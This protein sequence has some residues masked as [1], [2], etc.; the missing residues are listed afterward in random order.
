MKTKNNLSL[1]KYNT[2]HVDAKA[3]KLVIID[4]EK[5]ITNNLSS[6]TSSKEILILGGGS[7]I[8]FTKD[9][10]GTILKSN[11]Q[12][13]KAIEKDKEHIYLKVG[14]G[15][16]WDDLVKYAVKKGYGGIENL[17][18]IPGTVGAAPIQNIGAYGV[19]FDEVFFKLEGINLIDGSKKEYHH[20]DCGFGYRTSIFKE[21][22]KNKFFITYVTIRLDLKP[23]LKTNYR[24]IKE[25]VETQTIRDLDIKKISEIIREIRISK[26]PDPNKLGNAGSFFKNPVID[27]KHFNLLAAKYKDLVYFELQEGTYKIPAGWLIE[28]VGLKGKRFGNVAVHENQALVIVNLGNAT[29]KEVFELAQDIKKYIHNKF[30]INLEMEVNII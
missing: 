18:L 29:G 20:N 5:D 7:N 17:S 25:K 28:K 15:V 4:D 6:I 24:A 21:K 8:L 30:L 10:E 16:L 14:S 27:K 22:F 11:I 3:K 19:E 1:K 13:I 23:K 2:F 12:G 9:F 26:L